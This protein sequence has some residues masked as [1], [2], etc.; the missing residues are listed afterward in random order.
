MPN[1]SES[2]GVGWGALK[3]GAKHVS[4]K[5]VLPTYERLGFFQMEGQV[6]LRYFMKNNGEKHG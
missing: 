3:I 1:P 5:G 4:W 2:Y 6:Q